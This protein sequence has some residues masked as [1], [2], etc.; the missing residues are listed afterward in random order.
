M[1]S[2]PR[3]PTRASSGSRTARRRGTTR[4]PSPRCATT[5]SQ[6]WWCPLTAVRGCRPGGHRATP[7]A[8]SPGTS[9]TTPGRWKPGAETMYAGHDTVLSLA[10]RLD[11]DAVSCGYFD[12]AAPEML[13][14]GRRLGRE[15]REWITGWLRSQYRANPPALFENLGSWVARLAAPNA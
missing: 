11:L 4:W 8:A 12:P 10:K 14:N 5:S 3:P 1:S 6:H 13:I 7:P 9:S 2:G 15:E